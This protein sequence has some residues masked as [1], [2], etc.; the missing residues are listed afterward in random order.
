LIIARGKGLFNLLA[1]K[2]SLLKVESLALGKTE[3]KKTFLPMKTETF[4]RKSS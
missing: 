3:N 4:F 2:I 1:A